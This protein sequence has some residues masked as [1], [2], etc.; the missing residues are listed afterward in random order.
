MTPSDETL[1]FQACKGNLDAF[2]QL[3]T[4]YQQQVFRVAYRMT[5]N[6]EESEDIAQ[7]VFINIYRKFSQFDPSKRF[8]PW[9]YRIAVNTCISNIRRKKKYVSLNLDDI[10]EQQIDLHQHLSV[11]PLIKLEQAQLKETINQALK[12]IPEHYRIILILRYQL[13]LTNQE[14][15]EILGISR[16]NVEVKVHRA[17]KNLRGILLEQLDEGRGIHGLQSSK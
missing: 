10:Q 2:E 17:R 5:N 8:A 7:E 1:A 4:R 15:A 12:E 11:D 9:L 3:V 13:D 16:E 14:I 6:R